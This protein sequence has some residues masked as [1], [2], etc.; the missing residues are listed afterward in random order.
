MSRL[1]RR[2]TVPSIASRCP[3]VAAVIRLTS[4][5]SCTTWPSPVSSVVNSVSSSLIS[6]SRSADWA[7]MASTAVVPLCPRSDSPDISAEMSRARPSLLV[8]SERIS[9]PRSSRVGA[10]RLA[11]TSRR[12]TGGITAE[13]GRTAPLGSGAPCPSMTFT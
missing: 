6:D 10:S 8:P 3:A 7:A 2:R 1:G 11:S 13:A 4:S 12:S 5:T 9:P